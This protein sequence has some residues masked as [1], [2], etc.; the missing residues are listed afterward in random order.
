MSFPVILLLV[1]TA[2]EPGGDDSGDEN[3]RREDGHARIRVVNHADSDENQEDDAEVIGIGIEGRFERMFRH[4]FRSPGLAEIFLGIGQDE[5][6][7]HARK[8][9]GTV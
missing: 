3:P 2:G 6:G 7:D 8:N 9:G 5:P 4:D 1:Q